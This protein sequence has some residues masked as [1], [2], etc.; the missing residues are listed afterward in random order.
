MA[1]AARFPPFEKWLLEAIRGGSVLMRVRRLEIERFR[2]ISRLDWRFIGDT[3]ALVGPG[4]TGKSTVLDALERLL[5]PRWNY[6]FDDSDFYDL[7]PTV[8]LT[9]RA[10]VTDVPVVLLRDAKF[11]LAVQGFDSERSEACPPSGAADE[12]LALVVELVVD[13]SLE[14]VWSVVDGKDERHAIAARDRE[15]L[16]MLRLGAGIDQHLAWSRGSVLARVTESGDEV[17]AVVAEALRKARASLAVGDLGRLSEAAQ[18]VE[19]LGKA[20]GAPTRGGLKP[21]LDSAPLSFSGGSLSLHD[22]RVPLRRAGLGTKR[23]IAI[24]MQ[25]HVV[26]NEGAILIDEFEHGLEPHR[27][28]QLLRT[29]RG[30]PPEDPGG[31]NGQ[32]F[33]TT[34]APAVLSELEASEISVM[35]RGADGE[36]V[37]AAVSADLQRVV[38][39][40]PEAIIARRV[41]VAEGATEEGLLREVEAAWSENGTNFA[42]LGTAIVDG[43]GQNAPRTAGALSDL[44]CAVALFVDA[45]AAAAHLSQAKS[46]SVF[47]WPKGLA[48][49]N[50]LARDLSDE[51]FASM[52]ALAH[53]S[54]KVSRPAERAIRDALAAAAGRKP[55]DIGDDLNAWRVALPEIRELFGRVSKKNG[56]FKTLTMGR[57]LGRIVVTDWP[58]LEGKALRSVLEGLRG[59]AEAR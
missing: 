15:V 50:V 42:Y 2:G 59:F 1:A 5:T 41:I 8:P 23:L 31:R 57:D 7:D 52:V 33:L 37:V 6:P 4:D 40:T 11:G 10:T 38:G 16:G 43:E 14:P 3:A 12:A 39:R 36:A 20:I 49:E 45:D 29:L 48:T 55:A 56:W 24:A 13:A 22:G 51:G 30:L 54:P 28:R 46:A 34:H 19:K 35:R 47:P 18:R 58:H 26:G 17:A 9:I 53:R 27:I 21:H 25:R 32:L 44:G